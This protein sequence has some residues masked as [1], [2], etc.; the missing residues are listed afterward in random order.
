MACRFRA[1]RLAAI[2]SRGLG[3]VSGHWQGCLSFLAGVSH[4]QTGE[5]AID[6]KVVRRD[7]VCF[8]ISIGEGRPRRPSLRHPNL[9]SVAPSDR[10]PTARKAIPGVRET[11]PRLGP[12]NS[13]VVC[14]SSWPFRLC[15]LLSRTLAATR[16]KAA[17]LSKRRP[18]PCT[19]RLSRLMCGL[20]L[21]GNSPSSELPP[22]LGDGCEGHKPCH[23]ACQKRRLASGKRGFSCLYQRFGGHLEGVFGGIRGGTAIVLF[24]VKSCCPIFCRC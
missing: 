3:K 7:W 13:P 6:S 17:S 10:S 23:L 1:D 12:D 14:Y 15:F 9:R 5:H 20:A 24:P 21:F 4:E 16:A 22:D 11:A 18:R 8:V 2:S 19:M